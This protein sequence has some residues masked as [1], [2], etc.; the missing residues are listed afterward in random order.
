MKAGQHI[1]KITKTSTI[2]IV[3]NPDNAS[4]YTHANMPNGTY[5]IKA[6]FDEV[7]M[8]KGNHAYKSLNTLEGVADLDSIQVTVVGSMFDDLNN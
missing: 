2:T 3:V 4:L 6:W 1:Y 7:D 8:K 5:S